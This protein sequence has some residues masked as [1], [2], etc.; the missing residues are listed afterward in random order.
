[1]N[2][3]GENEMHKF[4]SP[5]S[6]IGPGPR[7]TPMSI[8]KPLPLVKPLSASQGPLPAVDD[9]PHCDAPLSAQPSVDPMA[10][11]RPEEEP[12]G[13]RKGWGPDAP[14]VQKPAKPE[15]PWER[16]PSSAEEIHSAPT[17][18]PTEGS[19][20]E[21]F[22]PSERQEQKENLARGLL[23]P[24]SLPLANVDDPGNFGIPTP[25]KQSVPPEQPSQ[26]KDITGDVIDSLVEQNTFAVRFLVART[27]RS[28]NQKQAAEACGFTSQTIVSQ[29]ENNRINWLD[30][31]KLR[32]KKYI[33]HINQLDKVAAFLKCSVCDLLS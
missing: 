3:P 6:L 18:V 16:K 20:P 27:A 1:M 8:C 32:Q 29:I 11:A 25:A 9:P 28:I 19:A 33:K 2:H 24:A 30:A 22:T 31:A 13:I 10:G 21:L 23:P 7:A 26:E 14:R 12:D 15:K 5:D 17:P 4:P